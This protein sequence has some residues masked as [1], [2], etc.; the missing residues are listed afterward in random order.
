MCCN[1]NCIF[2][3]DKYLSTAT[4][5]RLSN[6][7]AKAASGGAK[8]TDEIVDEVAEDVLAKLPNNF[9]TESALRRYPTSYEQSMNT[10][11]VQEMGRFNRL[12]SVIRS[13]LQNVRKAIKV[14]P[15]STH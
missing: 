13:S 9:D 8:S 3:K 11:L 7:K 12:L 6:I 14:S 4:I 2:H 1:N 5:F 10:V 15:W